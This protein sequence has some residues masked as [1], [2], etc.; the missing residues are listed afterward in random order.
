[1]VHK[2][3]EGYCVQI[4]P[5][6]RLPLRHISCHTL[7][8][9]VNGPDHR[10]RQQRDSPVSVCNRIIRTGFS[11]EILGFVCG[12]VPRLADL[13]NPRRRTIAGPGKR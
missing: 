8:Y 7:S 6:R 5:S 3:C 1:M 9:G 13:D 2:N 12:P 10:S 4:F 11:A